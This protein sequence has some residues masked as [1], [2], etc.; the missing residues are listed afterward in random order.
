MSPSALQGAEV[1]VRCL[2]M[3]PTDFFGEGLAAGSWP[4]S[5]ASS[6]RN[7]PDITLPW[8][9]AAAVV[10]RFAT[11]SADRLPDWD[12]LLTGAPARTPMQT[13]AWM[14]AC[15]ETFARDLPLNI[16]VVEDESGLVAIAPL[17]R[18]GGFPARYELLGLRE[19]AEPTDFVYRDERA[20]RALVTVLAQDGTPL[21]LERVPASSPMVTMVRGAF[22]HAVIVM[23][24]GNRAPRIDLAAGAPADSQLSSRLR[25]DLRRAQR[26]AESIG[27]V[28]YE[29]HAPRTAEE[30]LP[31]YEQ[32]LQIEAAGWKGRSGSAVIA[33]AGP[34]A[35]FRRYGTL[36]S[37]TGVLRLAFLRLNGEVAAMQYAV[38]WNQSFWLLKVGYDERFAKCSPGQLL[39]QH[40]LRDAA[41]RGLRSYEFLGSAER[42]TERWTTAETET[43]RIAVYPLG[44][45]GMVALSRDLLRAAGRKCARFLSTWRTRAPRPPA[46][47]PPDQQ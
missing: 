10:R 11:E 24:P 38:E 36:A 44:L 17:V 14:R 18:R 33:N 39:M 4:E 43:V 34:H 23:R 47:P 41:A 3:T 40:T 37:E 1:M 2:L 27:L 22:P 25:S 6:A 7:M 19:L 45:A 21:V 42:W 26:K 9:A 31:L 29:I 12:P 35:F 30:F 13:Q 15:A 46:D 28:A 32:A 20:L 8:P 16:V 5:L